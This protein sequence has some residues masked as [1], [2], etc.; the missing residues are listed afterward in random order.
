MTTPPGPHSPAWPKDFSYKNATAEKRAALFV[1]AMTPEVARTTLQELVRILVA[2]EAKAAK[3]HTERQAVEASTHQQ[4]WS[5][6]FG[7]EDK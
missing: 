7:P 4:I 6:V 5:L 1:D 3:D 2:N